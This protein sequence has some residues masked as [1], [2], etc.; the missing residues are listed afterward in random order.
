MDE[1]TNWDKNLVSLDAQLS[2]PDSLCHLFLCLGGKKSKPIIS[3]TY[4]VKSNQ[5]Q[6][7]DN[8]AAQFLTAIYLRLFS[9]LIPLTHQWNLL[10]FWSQ[11]TISCQFQLDHQLFHFFHPQGYSLFFWHGENNKSWSV[12]TLGAFGPFTRV[13]YLFLNRS[14]SNIILSC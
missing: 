6:I 1:C 7:N 4:Q 12:Q 5:N 8:F 10:S 14:S 2:I 9:T 13:L 11:L 3:K